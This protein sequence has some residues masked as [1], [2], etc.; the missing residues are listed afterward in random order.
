MSGLGDCPPPLCHFP[1]HSRSHLPPWGG[2]LLQA[3][4]AATRQQRDEL[5]ASGRRLARELRD[6]IY[7]LSQLH[8]AQQGPAASWRVRGLQSAGTQT[9]YCQLWA[10]SLCGPP[11]G[12]D[13]CE[14]GASGDGSVLCAAGDSSASSA[15]S[16]DGSSCGASP[17]APGPAP[18]APAPARVLA[19]PALQH[20]IRELYRWKAAADIAVARGQRPFQPLPDFVASYLAQQ[21]GSEG[22]AVAARAR[23]LQASVEAHAAADREV[24]LFG[25]AAGMLEEDEPEAAGGCSLQAPPGALVVVPA[26]GTT[27]GLP[28]SSTAAAAAPLVL[29]HSRRRAGTAAAQRAADALPTLRRFGASA[30][31]AAAAA[32]AARPPLAGSGRPFNPAGPDQ[33]LHPMAAEVHNLSLSV[34]GVEQ[35]AS[36]VLAGGLGPLLPRLD[37]GLRLAENQ[38]RHGPG[39]WVPGWASHCG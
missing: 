36:W 8:A 19:L 23:Q 28:R 7:T 37:L 34:P 5:D 29:Y 17:P 14:A 30:W 38:V 2:L 31:H 32:A 35:L 21:C 39:L 4:L 33:L 9:H 18:P 22:A 6:A 11:P 10:S 3:D 15:G 1:S 24:A 16:E 20:Q 27:A 26:G 12:A 13:G 25:L